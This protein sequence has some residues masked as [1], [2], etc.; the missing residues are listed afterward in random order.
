[1]T[2]K[3]TV[4]ALT[5]NIKALIEFKF[6]DP[7]VVIGEISSVS[8]SA[9]GHYYFIL[10]DDFSQIKSVYFKRYNEIKNNSNNY[11]PANGDKVEVTGNLK[12]YEKDGVYQILVKEIYYDSVGAFY[13]K[14]EETKR[15]LEAE[16]L[17][18]ESLKKPLPHLPVRIALLTSISGAAITD[19]LITSKKNLAKYTV[20]LWPI[21]VQGTAAIN[22]II[23]GLEKANRF[24]H[25][26]DA[27]VLMRGGGSLEDLSIFNEESVARALFDCKIPTLLAIGHERDITICDLV[28]D[29]RAATPTAAATLI[30]KVYIDAYK[31]IDDKMKKLKKVIE[32]VFFKY[33]Q[34]FD[35]LYSKVEHNSPLIK[36]ENFKNILSLYR[37]KLTSTM[38]Y[39]LQKKQGV[40]FLNNTLKNS[41]YLKI[42]MFRNCIDGFIKRLINL[43]PGLIVTRGYAIV[44]KGGIVQGDIKDI[45]LEDEI[46]IT[47][48]GGYIYSFVTGKK[49]VEA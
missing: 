42:N 32:F 23:S 41:Y 24:S 25:I 26:Y 28:A 9:S 3:Y 6:S 18:D 14:F 49:S 12:V 21:Q 1:M 5:K 10:K 48:K 34:N 11:T 8:H 19:F 39:H 40:I 37:E 31:S 35:K 33:M 29:K 4:T 15:K 46:E 22:E 7:I 30:S 13:K 17:F 27:L 45:N 2:K 36:I 43:D 44:K 47:M 20:D 38:N 16:G